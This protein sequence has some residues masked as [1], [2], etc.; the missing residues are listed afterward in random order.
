M[1]RLQDRMVPRRA[2]GLERWAYV[3]LTS[4]VS[5]LLSGCYPYDGWGLGGYE[6]S[7]YGVGGSSS[8]AHRPAEPWYNTRPSYSPWRTGSICSRCHY[9]P[10]R[11]SSR[12]GRGYGYGHSYGY[13]GGRRYDHRDHYDHHEN[14]KSS[15]SKKTTSTANE[16]YKLTGP[17]AGG[18]YPKDYHTLDWY[19]GRGYNVKDF[20]LKS[21]GGKTY[22][23]S[24]SSKKKSSSSKS[25]SSS[26]KKSSSSSSS[27]SKGERRGTKNFK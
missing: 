17:K 4:G 23:P 26:K 20:T 8:Y 1:R 18:G 2:R 7:S 19:K 13:G 12:Y 27:K 11:C 5:I 22:K 15:S 6:A 24:S 3:F 9:N 21:Q 14:K 10:C 16:K 25:S